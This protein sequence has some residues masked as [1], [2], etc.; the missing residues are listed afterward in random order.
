MK[1]GLTQR[2]KICHPST[3]HPHD[4][5]YEQ[6]C[7]LRMVHIMEVS[8]GPGGGPTTEKQRAKTRQR[9]ARLVNTVSAS[10]SRPT[11]CSEKKRF[12][13]HMSPALKLEAKTAA[14]TSSST[15]PPLPP[16]PRSCSADASR[17]SVRISCDPS[18]L[19]DGQPSLQV[20]GTKSPLN[21]AGSFYQSTMSSNDAGLDIKPVIKSALRQA[22]SNRSKDTKI[23]RSRQILKELQRQVK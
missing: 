21:K 19:H 11:R 5:T 7:F 12:T 1:K 8:G 10:N 17:K 23:L 22:S 20:V 4:I 9:S 16:K 14:T 15:K 18:N 3:N 2:Q 6:Q 13:W